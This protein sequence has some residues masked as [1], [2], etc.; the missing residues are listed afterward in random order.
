MKCTQNDRLFAWSLESVML[1]FLSGKKF[2]FETKSHLSSLLLC[3]LD[4]LE[5]H[6]DFSLESFL[7][8]LLC[9]T[10]YP[11]HED[12]LY[13]SFLFVKVRVFFHASWM[14]LLKSRSPERVSEHSFEVRSRQEDEVPS[15]KYATGITCR[16]FLIQRRRPFQDCSTWW[17]KEANLRLIIDDDVDAPYT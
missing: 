11:C 1:L 3:D 6:V 17:Q 7:T 12:D 2:F 10:R 15:S 4:S 14:L 5:F 8:T 9:F 13:T 16:Q